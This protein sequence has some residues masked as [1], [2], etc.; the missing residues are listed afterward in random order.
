MRF[1]LIINFFEAVASDTVIHK[2]LGL[3]LEKTTEI[4]IHRKKPIT[5]NVF[6]P[7]RVE[8]PSGPYRAESQAKFQSA[9]GKVVED[10]GL[11][12]YHLNNTKETYDCNQIRDLICPEGSMKAVSGNL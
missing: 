4:F 12:H 8:V 5:T 9:I 2:E 7:L 3:S 11:E 6:A 1:L 10:L